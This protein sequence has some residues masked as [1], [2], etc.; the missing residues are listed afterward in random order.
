MAEMLEGKK[1][2]FA[3]LIGEGTK[4]RRHGGMK[5]SGTKRGARDAAAK[6]VAA[7]IHR[8]VCFGG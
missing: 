7:A 3:G 2:E 4:A 6:E 8:L 5:G 1:D